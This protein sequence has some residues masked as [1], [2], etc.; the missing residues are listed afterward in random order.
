M[1]TRLIR[2]SGICLMTT[3]LACIAL[4]LAQTIREFSFQNHYSSGSVKI[5]LHQYQID[6]KGNRVVAED[7][8]VQ[9]GQTLSYIPEIRNERADCYVR[10]H[11]SLE[12][13]DS[14]AEQELS[15]DDI[16]SVCEDWIR[17]DDDFYRTRI[18]RHGESCDVFREINIPSSWTHDSGSGGFTI[19]VIADAIQS[20]NF[21]PDFESAMP[22]G[23]I[24]I[25]REK[26]DDTTDYC[27]TVSS[28]GTPNELEIRGDGGLEST[29]GDLFR[30]FSYFMAGDS[31][32][33]KLYVRNYSDTDIDLY[34]RIKSRNNGLNDKTKL[35]ISNGSNVLYRSEALHATTQEWRK[36]SSIRAREST[37]LDFSLYLP[38]D[39]D[40][41]YTALS[42]D[43]IWQFRT[44]ESE[45]MSGDRPMIRTGDEAQLMTWI[46]VLLFS[47]T[48]VSL[49]ADQRRK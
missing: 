11:I 13:N 48:A 33:D 43:V 34:F 49:M 8:V 45:S 19:K 42:D 1:R 23:S 22:W 39:S 35:T 46:L 32:E 10:V 18:L 27:S 47:V 36:I 37:R 6:D 38:E 31:F 28:F 20:D 14:F 2:I 5:S 24:R 40:R 4:L 15:V 3:M 41:E 17:I 9:P 16:H 44:V 29:T 7:G 12:M 21:T 26:D 30:N 25:E